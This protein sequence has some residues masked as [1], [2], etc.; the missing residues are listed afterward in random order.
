MTPREIYVQAKTEH[1]L[2]RAEECCAMG[3]YPAARR[4]IEQVFALKD[5][6]DAPASPALP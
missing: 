4:A 2:E 1:Y 3:R 6:D 5:P